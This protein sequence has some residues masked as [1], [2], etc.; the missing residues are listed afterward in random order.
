VLIFSVRFIVEF[1][2]VRQADYSLDIGLTTG[3]LLSIPFLLL[4]IGF[5]IWSR[6]K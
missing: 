6:K 4:G 5:I 3:Q 2:K 1:Y